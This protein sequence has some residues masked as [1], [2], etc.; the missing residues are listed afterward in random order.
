MQKNL[1]LET[2]LA[3]DIMGVSPKT[4]SHSELAVNAAEIMRANG[5]SQLLVVNDANEYHGVV[6]FHDLLREGIV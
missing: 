2:I 4:I 6:H 1:P 3:K 5:I